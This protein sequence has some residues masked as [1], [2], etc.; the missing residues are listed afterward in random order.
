[1]SELTIDEAIEKL[2]E[3][4]KEQGRGDLPVR[5]LVDEQD[6]IKED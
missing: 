1:M 4:K 3:I 2:T 5:V 6:Q